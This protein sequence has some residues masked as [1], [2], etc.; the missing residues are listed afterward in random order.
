MAN[1]TFDSTALTSHAAHCRI[2]PPQ[3]RAYMGMLP[4]V[5]GA[6]AQLHGQGARFIF[7][8]GV[9]ESAA[10]STAA[11]ALDD[12]M[13]TVRTLQDLCDGNTVAAFVGSDGTSYSNCMLQTYNHGRVQMTM[14]TTTTYQALC[15]VSAQLIQLTP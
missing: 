2:G 3:A 7:V 13:D 8:T 12:L 6:Y 1:P 11:L 9:G 4:G 5:N 10:K 15:P 14:P